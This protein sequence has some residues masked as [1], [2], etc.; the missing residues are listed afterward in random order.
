MTVLLLADHFMDR[1]WYYVS[2]DWPF[3]LLQL[4]TP[5]TFRSVTFLYRPLCLETD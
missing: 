3:T 5:S 2:Y 1:I 4:V